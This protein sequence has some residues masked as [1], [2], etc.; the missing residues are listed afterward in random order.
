V[1]PVK[2][3][4]GFYIPEDD[5]VHSDRR[6]VLNPYNMCTV[7]ELGTTRPQTTVHELGTTRP[8]TTVRRSRAFPCSALQAEPTR[9][10][11]LRHGW[12]M[13]FSRHG[14]AALAGAGAERGG[15][16]GAVCKWS[17]N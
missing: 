6:E 1:S 13:N 10:F 16:R 8:Q 12:Q 17:D 14:L 4:L 2:Y 15:R 11:T 9:P 5:I 7:H 3:E